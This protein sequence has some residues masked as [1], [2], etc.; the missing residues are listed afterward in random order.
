VNILSYNTGHDGSI[1]YL[2]SDHLLVSIEAEKNSNWRHS[3]ISSRDVFNALCELD[4]IPD[5]ICRSGW[6]PQD[7]YEYL[8]GSHVQYRGVS[9]SNV[10][11]DQRRLLGRPVHYFSSSHE[12]SHLLCAFGMSSLP[13]GTTCYALVWEG[14]IGAFYEIDSALNIT[15]LAD[16]L[17]Q[18]GNRYAILYGLADPTFPKDGPYP[19]VE[20]AGKLMALASFS[21]RSTPS[22][23][24]WRLLD[25]LLD[26]PR[27]ELSTY[28]DLEKSRHYNVGVH[29]PDF[30]DFAGIYSDKIFD[31]FYQFAQANMKKRLPLVI[32]GGCGLNCDWNTKWKETGLFPEVFVPP[33]ANDSGSAIGTAIDAQFHFTGNPK[34]DW[35]VYSGLGF[36]TAGSF[37]VA[38]YDLCEKNYQMIAD[39]LA[40]DLILGWV[41]GKYEIGPRALGNRSILAAPFQESTRARL[42]EI[43]QREQFRPIAPVCLEEE[44]ARW[45]GCDHASP[46]MLYTHRV[47]TDALAAVTHVNGTARIQTV[48]SLSN[49]NLY[50]L[51]VAFKARTGYGVLCNTSLNFKGRGFINKIT[52]LSEYALKHNLDGFV[53]EE[54]TYLLKSSRRYQEYLRLPNSMATELRI[55]SLSA[56]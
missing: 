10:I 54:R 31:V 37:D 27:R 3:P 33:V 28:Q 36:I 15:L 6:W 22:A 41:S 19:R 16:V 43:K 2:K 11:I 49:R 44:A 34:I 26:G 20:D 12:R 14:E 38:P 18:V 30:R 13:K 21:N 25:F 1:A 17:N 8:H 46:F 5:V 9:K 39:M 32:A 7:H 29:D 47:R 53:V 50:E 23:E 52:D 42:N 4:E 45:F 24:E 40:Y 56:S 51:L 55:D 48:S 35:S